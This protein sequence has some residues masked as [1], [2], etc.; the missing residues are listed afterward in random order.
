MDSNVEYRQ[1]EEGEINA[2][3]HGIGA[4]RIVVAVLTETKI[5]DD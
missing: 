5:V 4:N 1:Q 3:G 2:G